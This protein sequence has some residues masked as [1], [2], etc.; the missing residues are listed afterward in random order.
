MGELWVKAK[1]WAV[2]IACGWVLLAFIFMMQ[3]YGW[4]LFSPSVAWEKL[5]NLVLLRWLNSTIITGLLAIIAALIGAWA[6]RQQSA[7][8]LKQQRLTAL[9]YYWSAIDLTAKDLRDGRPIVDRHLSLLENSSKELGIVD[10][11]TIWQGVMMLRRIEL[12]QPLKATERQKMYYMAAA[13]KIII[14]E[15]ISQVVNN[16][17]QGLSERSIDFT[18]LKNS[19]IPRNKLHE[20]EIFFIARPPAASAPH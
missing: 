17:F 8:V 4:S 9:R 11:E 20:L 5:G 1:P 13:S 12:V 16:K 15:L 6:L 18:P 14:D 10:G 2:G 7:E 19:S 3:R